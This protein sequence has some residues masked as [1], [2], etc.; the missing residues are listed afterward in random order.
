MARSGPRSS[1]QRGEQS[2]RVLNQ[3]HRR[4]T[5]TEVETRRLR[6]RV[7]LSRRRSGES[8]GGSEDCW[9]GLGKRRRT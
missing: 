7:L 9:D 8:T 6:L 3:G 1:P 2:Q 5:A 4:R